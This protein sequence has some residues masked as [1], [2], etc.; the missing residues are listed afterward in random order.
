MAYICNLVNP[1]LSF[2]RAQV[3]LARMPFDANAPARDGQQLHSRLYGSRHGCICVYTHE[4]SCILSLRRR[5]GSSCS[6][7][8]FVGLLLRRAILLLP[9]AFAKQNLKLQT[10][11][12]RSGYQVCAA[13]LG[14][15]QER[16]CADF[17]QARMTNDGLI[18]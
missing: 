5:G 4:G 2:V 18:G 16:I 7:C 1:N 14:R 11:T 17:C 3:C 8:V 13:I 12:L 6:N 10:A 15:M 9:Y